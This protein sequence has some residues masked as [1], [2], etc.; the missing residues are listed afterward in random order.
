M[1][2]HEVII[3]GGGVT[4]CSIAYHLAERGMRDVAVLERAYLTSGATGRCGAGFRHQWGTKTNCLLAKYAIARL[5]HLA[6]ELDYPEGIEIK[7]EGYLLLAYTPKM[8]EQF[9]KN[10]A[11]Q[12][13]LGI[14]ARWVTPREAREIVPFLNTEGLLGATFCP[15]DGHANPFKVTDAYARAAR[16][17]GVKIHT[18]T[19]VRDIKIEGSLKT[20]I[21]NR[22]TFQAP[23][24]VNAAGGHA[25]EIGR[26]VGVDLPIV[27]ERHQILVTEPVEQVLGP[28]VM[29]FYHNLYCQQTP[30]GS[31]IM[32]LGDPNEPKEYNV[33]SSWQ[34]LTQMARKAVWLLPVLKNV[35]VVR[36]WAGVYDMSPDRQP[37]L[38]E[39]PG[40]PGFYVAAGFSGHGFMIAP[41]TGQLM[42]EV[43]LGLPTTL[44]VDMFSLS[45][46][47]TGELFVEPSVV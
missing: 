32:G 35:R 22:G 44:P 45:R 25:A 43:I 30:H 4:G 26:M 38:G 27:P 9:K 17:L 14:D 46:F 19:E 16:R 10:L 7:Q 11:L 28:M 2:R 24:V 20:V 23:V 1:N 5:E 31:F 18:Y 42:A 40:V 8:E 13:S 34:F 15:K 47:T 29:S 39:V 3:I 12:K 41:M 37:V 6:E 36:Q 33:R 21:T